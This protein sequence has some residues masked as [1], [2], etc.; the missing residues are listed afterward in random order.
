MRILQRGFFCC[1]Y[2]IWCEFISLWTRPA[3]GRIYYQYK[4][5][6]CLLNTGKGGRMNSQVN[7]IIQYFLCAVVLGFTAINLMSFQQVKVRIVKEN[8]ILRLQ[9]DEESRV[10]MELNIGAEFDVSETVAEWIKVVLPPNKDGIIIT[11]YVHKSF[12]E[13]SHISTQPNIPKEKIVQPE[14]KLELPESSRAAEEA[15]VQWKRD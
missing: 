4:V 8:A 2:P 7:K 3:K 1:T 5:A 9:P 13:L 11:G 10:I 12:V 14:L 6:S 15:H